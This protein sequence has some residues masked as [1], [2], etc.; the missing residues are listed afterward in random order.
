MDEKTR[1]LITK[2][3]SG[4]KRVSEAQQLKITKFFA[5]TTSWITSEGNDVTVQ[6][7]DWV[8]GQPYV[9]YVMFPDMSSSAA[10]AKKFIE[11]Y[12]EKI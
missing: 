10:S 3:S 8:F 9:N 7:I 2:S 6:S 5:K 12:T 11:T 4:K 1:L